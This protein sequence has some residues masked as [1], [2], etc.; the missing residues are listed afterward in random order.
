MVE[1]AVVL[2]EIDQQHGLAPDLGIGR[3]RVQHLLQKPGALHR[4]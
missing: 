2:V 4:A 1:I 3:Q